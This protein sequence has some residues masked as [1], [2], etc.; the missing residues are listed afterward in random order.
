MNMQT[1]KTKL[2]RELG[3]KPVACIQALRYI[4]LLCVK[5]I[6]D[7]EVAILSSLVK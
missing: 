4:Y 5:T 7:H 2:I 1:M 3:E 6:P